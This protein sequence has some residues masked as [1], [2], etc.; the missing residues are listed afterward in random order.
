MGSSKIEKILRIGTVILIALAAV[1][2]I[3]LANQDG[4][5]LE[6][7]PDTQSKYVV[8]MLNYGYW[9]TIIVAIVAVVSSLYNLVV[10]PKGLRNAVIGVLGLGAIVVVAYLMSSG[11]DFENFTDVTERESKLVSMGLNTFYIVGLLAVLSVVYSAVARIF[12]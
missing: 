8:P 1:F 6:K 4:E 12:K 3:L 7:D 10:N 2:F 9:L 5:M 11:A